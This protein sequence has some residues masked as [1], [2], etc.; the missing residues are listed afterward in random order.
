MS[1][2]FVEA[3]EFANE[4]HGDQARKGT[5]IPYISHLL[6]VA[7]IVLEHGGDEDEAIAAL[8]HDTVEDCGGR[9]VMEK[10]RQRFGEKI[11]G[12][13]DGCTETDIRPKPPWKERKECYIA[14]IK[15]SNPSVRL[16]SCADKIHNAQS[17]LYDYRSAG[18]KVW[19]RFNSDKKETLWFYRSLV[20]VYRE[21]GDARPI[22]NEIERVVN[23]LEK[24]IIN[25]EA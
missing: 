4:A 15:N 14:K 7:G 8:L 18:E 13:V 21:S 2:R 6:I 25:H 22:F 3:L 5:N 20:K 12:L 1:R 9:T 17:I 11:A 24:I 10:I 19:D 23:E 16:I